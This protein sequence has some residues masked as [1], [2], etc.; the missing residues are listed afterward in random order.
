M[1]NIQN[2][3]A[4]AQKKHLA[5]VAKGLYNLIR[6]YGVT[7]FDGF[8]T[9]NITINSSDTAEIDTGGLHTDK[10]VWKDSQFLLRRD[11]K[12][13]LSRTYYTNWYESSRKHYYNTEGIL[14]DRFFAS[15]DGYIICGQVYTNPNEADIR[16]SIKDVSDALNTFKDTTAPA[17][18][19]TKTTVNGLENRIEDLENLNI[20]EQAHYFDGVIKDEI[21]LEQIGTNETHSAT[22]QI[23]YSTVHEHFVLKVQGTGG[24]GTQGSGQTTKYYDFWDGSNA[25]TQIDLGLYISPSAMLVDG[26]L[27]EVDLESINDSL[28]YIVKIKG[29]WEDNGDM[30]LLPN[31]DNAKVGDVYICFKNGVADRIGMVQASVVGDGIVLAEN[32][33]LNRAKV[34]V[35]DGKAYIADTNARKPRLIGTPTAVDFVL[36]AASNNAISNSAVAN[37]TIAIRSLITALTGRVDDKVDLTTFQ[38]VESAHSAAYNDLDARIRNNADAYNELNERLTQVASSTLKR[39]KVDTLPTEDIDNNTIYIVPVVNPNTNKTDYCNEYFY[40]ADRQRFELIGTSRPTFDDYTTSAETNRYLAGL[41][42]LYITVDTLKQMSLD[43]GTPVQTTKIYPMTV[44]LGDK[45]KFIYMSGDA[46]N[47]TQ[48]AFR[49]SS[50]DSSFVDMPFGSEVSYTNANAATHIIVR[51]KV[52]GMGKRYGRLFLSNATDT[53]RLMTE[54]D[55]ED[56]FNNLD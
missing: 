46:T 40:D 1:D 37:E 21:T 41:G 13:T 18:Y 45:L 23:L 30:T 56:I 6:K 7:P 32:R 54:A 38:R 36:N 43:G 3:E 29:S 48:I 9:T 4:F 34:Y 31:L 19:A 11:D 15:K 16:K 53:A 25:Y 44:K 20:L 12:N 49:T 39:R 42:G 52:A 50:G 33:A 28:S 24:L 5:G 17:T 27:I 22:N 26:N 2:S 55:V 35:W 14:N 10:I 8:V 47:N 51:S